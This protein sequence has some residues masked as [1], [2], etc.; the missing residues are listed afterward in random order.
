MDTALCD[1]WNKRIG[2]KLNKRLGWKVM[3]KLLDKLF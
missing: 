2:K 3:K 1:E